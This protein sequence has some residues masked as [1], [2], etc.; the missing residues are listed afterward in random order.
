M[1]F[2]PAMAL[3][4]RKPQKQE[5]YPKRFQPGIIHP[6]AFYRFKKSEEKN[7]F[8]KGRQPHALLFSFIFLN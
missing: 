4:Y 3:C 5:Y 8:Q 7:S 1:S 2:Y 6:P